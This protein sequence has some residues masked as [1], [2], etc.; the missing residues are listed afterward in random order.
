MED[1]MDGMFPKVLHDPVKIKRVIKN[2]KR[3]LLEANVGVSTSIKAT[4]NQ[5][6]FDVFLQAQFAKNIK[7][8]YNFSTVI[9]FTVMSCNSMRKLNKFVKVIHCL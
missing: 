4:K 3:G 5:G 2:L 9:I 6:R 8:I 7:S 1:S